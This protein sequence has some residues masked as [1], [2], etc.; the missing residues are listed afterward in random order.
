[1]AVEIDISEVVAQANKKI[2]ESLQEHC[3]ANDGK[4]PALET[5]KGCVEAGVQLLLDAVVGATGVPLNEHV[6]VKLEDQSEEKDL[7]KVAI[8]LESKSPAG[9][10]VVM[11][12]GYDAEAGDG[13]E[14]IQ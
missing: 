12:F 1:M 14:F 7:T 8:H 3:I 9:A 11:L 4:P 6:E 13:E 2:W 5:A 10:T